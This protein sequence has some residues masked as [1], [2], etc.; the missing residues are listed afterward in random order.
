MDYGFTDWNKGAV[1][2]E[3][4]NALGQVVYTQALPMYSGFQ[5]L[6]VSRFASGMYDIAIKRNAALVAAAKLVK[7]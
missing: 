7:E 4:T 2:L 5:R 6:D 3:I 1:S